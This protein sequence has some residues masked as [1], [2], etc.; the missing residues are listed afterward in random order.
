MNMNKRQSLLQTIASLLLFPSLICA[1]GAMPSVTVCSLLGNSTL[2]HKKVVEIHAELVLGM[3]GGVLM[4]ERC[5]SDLGAIRLV[6]PEESYGNA[7]I[8]AMVRKVMSSH[9]H[10]QVILI[11]SFDSTPAGTAA[12]SF[13]LQAVP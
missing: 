11:G 13:T 8:A 5:N 4:D 3:H 1:T 2:Y 12:G 6:I 10:A 9:A 7:K